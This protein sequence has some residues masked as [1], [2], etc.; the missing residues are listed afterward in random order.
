LAEIRIVTD[1]CA[2]FVRPTYAVDHRI[3]VIPLRVQMGDSPAILRE[4]VDRELD[5]ED[6]LRRIAAHNATTTTMPTLLPPTVDQFVE[7]YTRLSKETDQIL[8]IHVSRGMHSTWQNAKTAAET[9]LGRCNIAVLDSQTASIGQAV[10][11]E[12]AV[13]LIREGKDLADIVR[14][15]RRGTGGVYCVFYVENL[16]YLE[17]SGLITVSQS[18]LGTMLGIKPFLTIEEGILHPMEKVRTRSQ[19]IDKLV[20]FI[21]EFGAVDRLVILQNT[22]SN[23]EQTRSLQER[24]AAELG[25]GPFPVVVYQPSLACFLGTDA[26]GVF[27]YEKAAGE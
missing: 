2:H 15:L 9:L 3:S 25:G 4:G 17:H 18:A 11:V 5:P 14:I 12:H 1:S 20:E 24:L 22:R 16:D 19:A 8:S 6:F 7:L 27:V 13:Q 26:M 23:T 21:V 10:L